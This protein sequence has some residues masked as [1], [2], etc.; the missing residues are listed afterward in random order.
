MVFIARRRA[1]EYAVQ[2]LYCR[3]LS[4][5]S[6]KDIENYFLKENS[7]QDTDI[8]YFCI[9]LNRVSTNIEHLDKLMQPY[10]SRQLQQLGT[11]EKSILRIAFFELSE[12]MDIPY[13]VI[14]NEAIDLARKFGATDSYKFINGVLDKSAFKIRRR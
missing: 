6:I 12:K 1:R 14:I 5:N 9:L 8:T 11:V 4:Q 13:K 7:M 2:A 10:L 3:D